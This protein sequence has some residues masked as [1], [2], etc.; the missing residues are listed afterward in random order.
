M[1]SVDHLANIM[2]HSVPFNDSDSEEVPK[3]SIKTW[4]KKVLVEKEVEK[5]DEKIEKVKKPKKTK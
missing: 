1:T 5:S 3:Q 2:P 4:R